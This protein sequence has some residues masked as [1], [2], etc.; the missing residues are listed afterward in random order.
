MEWYLYKN[1]L[2]YERDPG[3]EFEIFL[4][5]SESEYNRK[6]ENMR[7]E[8]QSPQKKCVFNKE[9]SVYCHMTKNG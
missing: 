3:P 1:M 4:Y 2:K 5:Y 7:V 8:C 6:K 9:G